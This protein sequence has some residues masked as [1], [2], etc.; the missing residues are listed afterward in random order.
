M[1]R[2][3][4]LRGTPARTCTLHLLIIAACALLFCWPVIWR[5]FWPAF[6][7]AR[8]HA[9]WYTNFSRQ[10]WA[11]ELYPRWLMD[12]NAG[13]GSPTFFYYP[14]VPYYFT[15]LFHPFFVQDPAGWGQLGCST[16][17]GL[18][19][20]GMAMRAWLK[21]LVSP[22][23][24]LAGALAYMLAPY[25]LA[26]DLYMRGAF[27]EFWAFAWLPLVLLFAH[28]IQC[29]QRGGMTGLAFSYALLIATHLPTTLVFSVL[30]LLYAFFQAI[31]SH[32]W[33]NFL[34]TVV[35]MAWGIGI[36]AAYL[37]PAMTMQ[38]HVSMSALTEG[39]HFHYSSHFLFTALNYDS[40]QFRAR[41]FWQVITTLGLAFC[42]F[43]LAT[44]QAEGKCQFETWFWL[45]T[46]I[47]SLFLM[48]PISTLIWQ[49]VPKLQFIQ[50]PW[51]INSML[52]LAACSLLGLGL[53]ALK[54]PLG[55]LDRSCLAGLLTLAA[56]WLLFT[57]EVLLPFSRSLPP[58]PEAILDRQ[59]DAGEY[60]T[61]WRSSDL[62]AVV[63][64]L[65][66]RSTP[67]FPA[68]LETQ[69]RLPL[70]PRLTTNR[71]MVAAAFS[72]GEGQVQ[73]LK[74]QPRTIEL[75][76]NSSSQS[77]LLISRFYYPG[78]HAVSGSNAIPVDPA[79]ASGLIQISVSAGSQRVTLE[80]NRTLPEK[81]GLIISG[82]SLGGILF[83][84][85][86]FWK[87][88]RR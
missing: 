71:T 53:H 65:Q 10:L 3:I 46:A 77:T 73:F 23:P 63:V 56:V 84:L 30:P 51:R 19:I 12:M 69:H 4:P 76:I 66:A 67:S 39:S 61:R 81:A 79:F 74:W 21:Q 6:H 75:N 62:D 7:D 57:S 43:L 2:L 15:S 16:A 25:H 33:L 37:L 60:A 88:A 45:G 5:G 8:F 80:M 26:T 85:L 50:F 59:E 34:K 44:K 11:G 52:V 83:H 55:W 82:L 38:E 86:V 68:S 40:D 78:W 58:A 70:L 36:A 29:C 31:K 49:T 17:L 41:L 32:R 42:G 87:Q 54:R 24:A 18:V 35:A 47:F 9:I 13:L 20:S 22:G 48:L 1:F 14:P 72:Q 27:A 28:R 64:S